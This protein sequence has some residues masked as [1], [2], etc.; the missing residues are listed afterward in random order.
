MDVQVLGKAG[1]GGVP[2]V[3]SDIHAVR[4]KR[5]FHQIRGQFHQGPECGSFLRGMVQ[6]AGPG[7]SQ[8]HHQV[9]VG[10]WK[11]V[12]H[13]QTM[14][15]AVDD[16]CRLVLLGML[17]GVGKEVLEHRH[18]LAQLMSA[19]FQFAEIGHPPGGPEIL[20]H[21][22]GH[23][24]GVA[25]R[26]GDPDRRSESYDEGMNST[27]ILVAMSGGVDSS[28]AAALLKEAGHEV[29]GVFMRL[30]SPGDALEELIPGDAC[31]VGKVRIGKQGCCSVGDAE[32]ARL[33]AARLDMPFYVVN[34]K[35][36]FG[37]II[38]HF[39]AEYD[40]GRTPNPCVRCNDWLKFGRLHEYA[41][42]V[43]AS[44]VASGHYARVERDDATGRHRLLRGVDHGKDQ[45]YVLFGTPV[46][47]LGEMMLPVGGLPKSRV[48]E[49]AEEFDLPVF[50]KPD[51]QEICFVPNDDY[52]GLVARRSS[53]GVRPGAIVD[54]T[55]ETIGEHPGHQH[56]T[57]GQRR[58]IGMA[59]GR[60]IY[61][62]AKDPVAN[63][64]T[65]GDREALFSS[66]CLASQVNWLVDPPETPRPC[67]VRIRYNAEPVNGSAVMVGEDR[68]EVRFESP[69]S[70]VAPGQAAVC[71]DGDRVLGGGWIDAPLP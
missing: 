70:S 49:L 36:E 37:R 51:S 59:F 45:S 9:P 24:L 29:I 1:S 19:S 11:T 8:G 66:G 47:R 10:I 57:I 68:I 40:A 33:V 58:K 16:E 21:R 35:Q 52:A 20:M 42:Q 50:D 22:F 31:D 3:D 39:V 23:Q 38:D 69:Q 12:Q 61:V 34:F 2:L 27:K 4:L 14:V 53:T 48:R 30:G 44:A 56:F 18:L 41:G 7:R 6:Q 46:D 67:T 26:V 13:E 32:D 71:Y 28:V 5:P 60:P 65:V 54:T 55:G 17:P 15:V 25:G 62:I 64:I 63:T 43:G